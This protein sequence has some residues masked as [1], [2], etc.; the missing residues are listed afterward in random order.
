[1]NDAT[2]DQNGEVELYNIVQDPYELNNRTGHPNRQELAKSLREALLQWSRN[3]DD[4][5]AEK[6]C[7]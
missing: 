1:M 2:P 3:T 6:V 7:L 4:C 5:F